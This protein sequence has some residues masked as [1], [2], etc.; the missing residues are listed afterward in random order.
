MA[1]KCYLCELLT[2]V[3]QKL[4]KMIKSI[5]RRAA[6]LGIPAGVYL[7]VAMLSIVFGDKLPPLFLVAVLL[8]LVS[9]IGLYRMQRQ[10]FVEEY[11][12]SDYASLWMLGIV[13]T[14]CGSLIMVLVA[15]VVIETMR[16]NWIYELAQY[17]IAAGINSP[18]VD[19]R[20]SATVIKNVVDR[21]LIPRVI[22]T[23]VMMFWVTTSMGSVVSSLTA[24]IAVKI[25]YKGGTPPPSVPGW[26]PPHAFDGDDEK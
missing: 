17:Q 5:Y 15:Y 20:E 23:L 6:E 24:I 3:T 11:G 12:F 2:D 18:N 7:T 21:G 22:D 10:R 4:C 16:P 8:L 19:L 26:N 1:G 14:L 9:P 25:P 13:V